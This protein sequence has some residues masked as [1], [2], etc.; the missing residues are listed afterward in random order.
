MEGAHIIAIAGLSCSGKSTTARLIAEELSAPVLSLDDYY[1]PL[2]ELTL[3]ERKRCNFDAPEMFDMPLLQ[4]HLWELLNSEPIA[5]PHYDFFEFTRVGACDIVEPAP[6]I[7]LEGQYSLFWS[8]IN[9]LC[10][11]RIFLDVTPLECLARRVYRDVHTRG[12]DE[13]EV[14]WRFHNHVL[15]MFDRH[16]HPSR[17]NATMVIEGPPNSQANAEKILGQVHVSGVRLA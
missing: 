10:R 16:I 17:E 12:R 3:E 1:L 11:T 2:T 14:R 15:P 13:T 7:V 6:Y 5:K 4:E 9:Q 8:E